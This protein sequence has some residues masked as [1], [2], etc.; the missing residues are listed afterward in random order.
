MEMVYRTDRLCVLYPGAAKCSGQRLFPGICGCSYRLFFDLFCSDAAGKCSGDQADAWIRRE[1]FHEYLSG[2]YILLP[3]H[4]PEFCVW[5]PICRTDLPGVG[6][7]ESWLCCG[8]G[9]V[10]MPWRPTG[11]TGSRQETAPD[12]PV[13]D[14]K[15]KN[16]KK[17]IDE[18]PVMCYS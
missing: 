3:D 5:L 1:T 17:K 9:C 13:I 11:V 15:S 14:K 18:S 10:E 2:A 16:N 12:E 4:P 7:F 6:H 8:V